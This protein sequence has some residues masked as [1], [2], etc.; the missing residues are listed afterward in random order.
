MRKGRITHLIPSACDIT[1]RKRAEDALKEREDAL[2]AIL[3]TAADAII[4][5]DSAEPS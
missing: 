2:R 3:E 1:E 4:T 5:I